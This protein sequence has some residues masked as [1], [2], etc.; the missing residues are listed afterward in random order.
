VVGDAVAG[1]LFLR[2]I[3]AL[4]LLFLPASACVAW[5]IFLRIGFAAVVGLEFFYICG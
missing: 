5:T 1:K 4:G 2:L 3:V